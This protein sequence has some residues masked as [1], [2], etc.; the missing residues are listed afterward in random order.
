[1]RP[2]E[3]R[4][5]AHRQ[6]FSGASLR[7]WKFSRRDPVPE[8]GCC[9]KEIQEVPNGLRKN[10]V[11]AVSS[12][13]GVDILQDNCEACRERLYRMWDKEYKAVCKKEVS[14]DCRRSVRF[15]LS[16]NIVCGNALS[17]MCVDE[18]Q[19]DTG[20]PRV[21]SEWAFVTGYQLQRSDYTFARLMQGDD[22]AR[23]LFGKKKR[24]KREEQMT[25]FDADEPTEKPSDEGE[26]L[27]KYV[28]H[29]R[30]VWENEQ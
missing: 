5:R 13:Y 24:K 20:E 22:E 18:N 12:L 7:R 6:P 29:Y 30:R 19:Q 26:F 8:A 27:K 11:L 14:E 9:K 15:I 23:D 2:R 28:T 1:M 16:R 25:L 17:L 3:N 21:F 10:S 4:D